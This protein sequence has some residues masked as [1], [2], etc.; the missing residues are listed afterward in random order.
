MSFVDAK[1]PAV[2]DSKQPACVSRNVARRSLTNH[3]YARNLPPQQ[4]LDFSP[5]CPWN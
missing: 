1:E 4:L 2:Q 3:I 5:E